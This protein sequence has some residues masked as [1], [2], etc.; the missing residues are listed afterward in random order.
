M[1]KN[2][3]FK[4]FN[5]YP[6]FFGA[7]IKVNVSK[8]IKTVDVKMKLKFWNRNYV[9]T[10]YGGSLYSM[11]DP[12]FMFLLLENLGNDYIVWDKKASISFKAPGK[13]VVSARFHLADEVYSDIRSRLEKEEKIYPEFSV[14]ILDGGNNVVATVTKI[15]YIKKKNKK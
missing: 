10:H 5:Y 9:G 7:G 2:L 6:P 4:L 3:F 1:K 13:G 12:F 14:D 15:I 8:D 11:C